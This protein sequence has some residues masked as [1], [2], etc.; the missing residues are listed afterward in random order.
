[1]KTVSFN[2]AAV[3]LAVAYFP[4]GETAAADKAA[5]DTPRAAE[6]RLLFKG[7]GLNVIGF[8]PEGKLLACAEPQQTFHLYDPGK[9][10]GS[11]AEWKSAEGERLIAGTLSPDGR[12]A[13]LL[14]GA[15]K[16]QSQVRLCH[17]STG[18]RLKPDFGMTDVGSLSFSPDGKSLAGVNSETGAARVW[19]AATGELEKTL[20]LPSQIQAG[21]VGIAFSPDGRFLAA[22]NSFAYTIWDI[23]AESI[24][25]PGGM[26]DI[27]I[28]VSPDWKRAFGALREPARKGAPLEGSILDF[29]NP[30]KPLPLPDPAGELPDWISFSE[31][32][33]LFA[34]RGKDSNIRFWNVAK[35]RYEQPSIPTLGGM[36]E[37]IFSPDKRFLVTYERALRSAGKPAQARIWDVATGEPR[38]APQAARGYFPVCHFDREVKYLAIS[39]SAGEDVL[40][41]N[42]PGVN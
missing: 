2:I 20:T 18:E 23:S 38:S 25:T 22:R 19:N 26:R 16:T 9:G 30:K 28:A 37:M 4:A 12:I 34:V 14:W 6:A 29:T 27:I 13:A 40:I 3:L 35:A 36:I 31:D 32:S 1:M 5:G 15:G 17:S 39:F 7:R 41:W 24:A 10:L 11:V 42:L 8:T 33:Q 21:W